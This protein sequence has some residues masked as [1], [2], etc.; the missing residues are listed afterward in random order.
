MASLQTH[1]YRLQLHRRCVSSLTAPKLRNLRFPNLSPRFPAS[2]PGK[3]SVFTHRGNGRGKDGIYSFCC[4]CRAGAE[5]E[6]VDGEE[7]SERPPFDIN[8]AVVL[9]GFAFEAY[10]SPPVS[11]SQ[12]QFPLFV[13]WVMINC[14]FSEKIEEN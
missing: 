2:L 9:A 6:K 12:L 8:L 7:G 5:I 4:V 3:V 10:S 14:L 13:P 1:H 11:V